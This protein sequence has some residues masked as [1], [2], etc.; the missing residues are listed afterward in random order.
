MRLITLGWDAQKGGREKGGGT[1][2]FHNT[3][4]RQEMD[5]LQAY[6]HDADSFQT[7][8]GGKILIQI[9]NN[10]NTFQ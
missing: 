8:F 9:L 2:G 3:A 1:R 4:G 7:L 10:K 6:M 5:T